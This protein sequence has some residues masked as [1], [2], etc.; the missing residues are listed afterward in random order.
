MAATHTGYVP[1][2]HVQDTNQAI[3]DLKH[4][5]ARTEDRLLAAIRHESASQRL[6][7]AEFDARIDRR[8]TG[9]ETRLDRLERQTSEVLDILREVLQRVTALETN[10]A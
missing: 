10:S 8:F 3:S 5:L 9:V 1:P 4:D 2:G 7:V 6:A